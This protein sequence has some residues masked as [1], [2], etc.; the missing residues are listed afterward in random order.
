MEKSEL[1]KPRKE[2]W[3]VCVVAVEVKRRNGMAKCQ[4]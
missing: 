4:Y 3:S 2:G 1:T